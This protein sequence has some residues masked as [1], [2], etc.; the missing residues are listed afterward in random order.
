MCFLGG[1]LGSG[2]ENQSLMCRNERLSFAPGPKL[3]PL[4]FSHLPP[5]GYSC[6][7]DL[8]P[9]CM[10]LAVPLVNPLPFSRE[11]YFENRLVKNSESKT[12]PSW[13]FLLSVPTFLSHLKEG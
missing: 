4:L 12:H 9:A 6:L 11:L 5:S 3:L 1:G 8:P 13:A 7:M 10:M 2:K